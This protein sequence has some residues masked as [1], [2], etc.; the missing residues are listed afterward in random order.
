[1]KRAA[2]LLLVALTTAAALAACR[3]YMPSNRFLQPRRSPLVSSNTRD[4]RGKFN[5]EKHASTLS[6]KGITCADC[7]RFDVLIDTSN[8]QMA[9]DLSMH[10]QQPGSAAC[11]YCHGPSD[12]HIAAAPS[13]CMTCHQNLL[14]L[15]P[16]NHEVAWLKV[17]A[18]VATTQP[19]QCEN[20]HKQAYCINCHEARDTIQTVVH[21][22][23]F[24]FYHSI[25]ARANPMQCGSCHRPDYCTNCHAQGKVNLQ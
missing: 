18:T 9:K 23:N 15:L 24:R 25:Q 6:A 11:H 5:H 20:C 14:P 4:A 22:R 12:T 2:A 19:A 8:E 7:H 17:H 16:T 13:A 21:D 1:V 10:A 3:Q